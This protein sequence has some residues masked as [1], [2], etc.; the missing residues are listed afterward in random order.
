MWPKERGLSASHWPAAQ[1]VRLSRGDWG[2]SLTEP[3]SSQHRRDGT[4]LRSRER[5]SLSARLPDDVRS[6]CEDALCGS[7]Y[8]RHHS[9]TLVSNSQ[10]SLPESVGR[11][12]DGRNLTPVRECDTFIFGCILRHADAFI[13]FRCEYSSASLSTS[14]AWVWISC[15]PRTRLQPRAGFK[16]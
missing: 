15:L 16:L 3:E 2:Q 14:P 5:R 13:K 12:F 7:P 6:L 10:L 11:M 9:V 4:Q 8:R 1:Q